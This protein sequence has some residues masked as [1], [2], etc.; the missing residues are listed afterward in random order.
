MTAK[1]SVVIPS[2]TSPE[3]NK[4]APRI[5]PKTTAP[6]VTR[7]TTTALAARPEVTG[8]FLARILGGSTPW[9]QRTYLAKPPMMFWT[10]AG[11]VMG[12]DMAYHGGMGDLTATFIYSLPFL[13]PGV[14]FWW[15]GRD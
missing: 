1:P 9:P 14:I 11:V 6:T 7:V 4:V 15:A 12:L 8:I 3:E 13:V 10:I 2:T 5:D